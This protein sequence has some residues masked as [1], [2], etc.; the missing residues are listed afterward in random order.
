MSFILDALKKSETERQ[1]QTG[2]EFASVPS[3]SDEP[4]SFKWLW[5]LAALL[6]V[7]IAVL[8]A[9]LLRPDAPSAPPA[10]ESAA[11]AGAPLAEATTAAG[12][13]SF[14]EQVAEAMN[15]QAELERAAA[16][17]VESET[18]PAATVTSVAPAPS[19]HVSTM[20]ELRINGE[21]QV[22]DLHLDIHVYSDVPA[23]RFVFINMVKHRE[24][25]QLDEGPVVSEITPEGVILDYQGRTFL[26]PRE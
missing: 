15:R 18:R 23:E 16:V 10:I 3:S 25:S 26:L 22:P 17:Q 1:R 24:R 6:V 19:R 4:R 13:P 8:L 5:I 2:A 9:I 21:L 20:D 14:E 7:N 12:E 11:P